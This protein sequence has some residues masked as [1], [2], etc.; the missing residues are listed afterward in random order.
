MESA[1]PGKMLMLICVLAFSHH[2]L[3]NGRIYFHKLK[4]EKSLRTP[5]YLILSLETSDV[6]AGVHIDTQI[7]IHSSEEVHAPPK[8]LGKYY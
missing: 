2:K 4:T 7:H 3:L 5:T 1:I 8:V 6:G